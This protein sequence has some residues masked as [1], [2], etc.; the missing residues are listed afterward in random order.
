MCFLLLRRVC[1][2]R[3]VVTEPVIKLSPAGSSCY[4]LLDVRAPCSCCKHRAGGGRRAATA[5]KPSKSP[6]K[7]EWLWIENNIIGLSD[8][9][10]RRCRLCHTL[11]YFNTVSTFKVFA[12]PPASWALGGQ[13]VTT[14]HVQFS[15]DFLSFFSNECDNQL[16][17]VT[18]HFV[19]LCQSRIYDGF[20][21]CCF[22]HVCQM[23][24]FLSFFL[25]KCI[26]TV[27][28]RTHRQLYTI[29]S[30]PLSG[31]QLCCSCSCR[32]RRSVFY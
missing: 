31:S 11:Q 30:Q 6:Q 1:G 21:C 32:C 10:P 20:C 3:S 24:H 28:P 8:V 16:Y 4:S 13:N 2:R 25:R 7:T 9:A 27:H 19:L 29:F 14:N 23:I 22:F 26:F 5:E 15:F 12:S 17:L 18:V